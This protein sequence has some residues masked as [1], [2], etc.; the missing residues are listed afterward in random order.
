M[1]RIPDPSF[2]APLH[3]GR[4]SRF[5]CRKSA[6]GIA[7]SSGLLACLRLVERVRPISTAQEKEFSVRRISAPLPGNAQTPLALGSVRFE[8]RQTI[9]WI[10]GF[11]FQHELGHHLAERGSVL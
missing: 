6:A 5:L 10:C 3:S 11:I 9:K 1:R 2:P 4:S 8:T 7:F